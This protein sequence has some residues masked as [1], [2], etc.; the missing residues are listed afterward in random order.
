MDRFLLRFD[1]EYF[2]EKSQKFKFRYNW[3]KIAFMY[4]KT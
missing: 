3:S 4:M 1:V 2:H